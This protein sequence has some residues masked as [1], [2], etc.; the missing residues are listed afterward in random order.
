MFMKPYW[1]NLIVLCLLESCYWI[2]KKK[3]GKATPSKSFRSFINDACG[4]FQWVSNES[5]FFF[6][7]SCYS[8]CRILDDKCF[9]SSVLLAV[10]SPAALVLSSKKE[11]S[12]K[13]I[14]K[15]CEQSENKIMRNTVPKGWFVCVQIIP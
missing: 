1:R 3:N 4:F 5:I 11:T 14:V 13:H 2:F 8:M 10:T 9:L 6:F 15:L 7:F 12:I